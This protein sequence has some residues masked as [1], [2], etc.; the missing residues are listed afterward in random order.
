MREGVTEKKGKKRWRTPNSRYTRY[1]GGV[2]VS[3]STR[4]WLE[5]AVDMTLTPH[6]GRRTFPCSAGRQQV[7]HCP[8]TSLLSFSH[9]T[10]SEV[11]GGGGGW[12]GERRTVQHSATRL[13]LTV[14]CPWLLAPLIKL[15]Q[16]TLHFE[17][18]S[19]A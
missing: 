14:L 11:G 9:T 4:S 8:A 7:T 18:L 15:G 19:L 10:R 13:H 2:G 6:R 17:L 1:A 16:E 5:R 3:V 12:D